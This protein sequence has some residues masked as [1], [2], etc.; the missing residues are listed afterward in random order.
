[1]CDYIYVYIACMY[2]LHA[3]IREKERA[4]KGESEERRERGKER[5]RKGESEERRERGKER[6]RKGES[7]ERRE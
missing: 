6:A 3:Y 4:R 5:A 1:M 2:I 7:E